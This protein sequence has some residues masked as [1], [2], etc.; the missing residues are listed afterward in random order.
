MSTEVHSA[1]Y[2]IGVLAGTAF[3]WFAFP[4]EDVAGK[5]VLSICFALLSILVSA[6]I[7]YGFVSGRYQ[8]A[9]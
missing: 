8:I 5:L 1:T 9:L 7:G 3:F 6:F 4:N 2:W